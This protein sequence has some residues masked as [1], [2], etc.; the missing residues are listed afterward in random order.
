M[1]RSSLRRSDR[2]NTCP[3][4]HP[5][6]LSTD[7][8]EWEIWG[9]VSADGRG[10]ILIIRCQ[11]SGLTLQTRPIIQRVL[12]TRQRCAQETRK[13][14]QIA[15]NMPLYISSQTH[16]TALPAHRCHCLR[17]THFGCQGSGRAWIY[18]RRQ[19]RVLTLLNLRGAEMRGIKSELRG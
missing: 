8:K 12:G 5:A 2:F 10:L 15:P 9:C 14:Q 4:N 11:G 7:F 3:K 16:H 19:V 17:R 18:S 1:D 6:P 13:E